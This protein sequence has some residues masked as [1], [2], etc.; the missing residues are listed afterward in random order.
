MSDW[1][2]CAI[3]VKPFPSCGLVRA[4]LMRRV[5]WLASG[6]GSIR[7]RYYFISWQSSDK[8]LESQQADLVSFIFCHQSNQMCNKVNLL[9]GAVNAFVKKLWQNFFGQS[10]IGKK[11]MNHYVIIGCK[12][13]Q[14]AVDA[15]DIIF[16]ASWLITL[17]KKTI[18]VSSYAWWCG[19]PSPCP[20]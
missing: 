6:G 11:N 8:S 10:D 18:D 13:P 9:G 19:H 17:E 7:N 20:C 5:A 2:S 14:S 16:Y 15:V 4:A 3:L 1:I 12:Y